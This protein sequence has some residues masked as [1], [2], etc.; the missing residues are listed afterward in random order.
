MD[1]KRGTQRGALAIENKRKEQHTQTREERHKQGECGEKEGGKR[2]EYTAGG[3]EMARRR[4]RR[5]TRRQ[6]IRQNGARKKEKRK[7]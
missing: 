1:A 5:A 2:G 7:E 6:P 4:S 3:K